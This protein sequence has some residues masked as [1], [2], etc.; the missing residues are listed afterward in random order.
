MD[1][2]TI[3][4][5][6]FLLC[7]L[8][9]L[10]N[11]WHC[12]ERYLQE[13][14]VTKNSLERQEQ[15]PFPMF[16]ISAGDFPIEKAKSLNLTL[17]GYNIYGDAWRNDEIDEELV[18]NK[19]SFE[20]ENIIEKIRIDKTLN[21]NSESY[22]KVYINSL[23]AVTK[24]LGI[25]IKRADYYYELKRYCM[26]FSLAAFKHGIQGI[27]LYMKDVGQPIRF[28]IVE[29]GGIYAQAKK[30]TRFT[31]SG[32]VLTY[33]IEYSVH[34]SLSLPKD[35]CYKEAAWTGDSCKLGII[36]NRIMQT[37]NCT[38]P[39]LLHSARLVHFRYLNCHHS[40]ALCRT[41]FCQI[42]L[43]IVKNHAYGRQP[44]LWKFADTSSNTISFPVCVKYNSLRWVYWS[45]SRK[46]DNVDILKDIL[47]LLC[48]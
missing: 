31:F 2:L 3:S 10:Y 7:F 32:G 25:E 35:P 28:H 22:E 46:I 38:T 48:A 20:F 14:T 4:K 24:D 37:F 34:H 6:W 23:D 39:W 41:P 36:N 18:Y 12:V 40:Y 16:C 26:K 5:F 17:R 21:S 45:Y 27:R 44:N 33:N 47:I 29:P 15:H 9:F 11:G 30:R 19:L 1:P 8:L 43:E 42:P 13:E